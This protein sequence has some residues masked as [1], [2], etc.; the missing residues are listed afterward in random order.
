[1]RINASLNHAYDRII[2][3]QWPRAV[4]LMP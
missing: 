1:M 4:S 3:P 2:N